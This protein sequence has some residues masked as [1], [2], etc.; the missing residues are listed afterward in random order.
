MT[1]SIL[2]RPYDDCMRCYDP[3]FSLQTRHST[4]N[5]R[6]SEEK[7]EGGRKREKRECLPPLSLLQ[8]KELLYLKPFSIF[9]RSL[10]RSLTVSRTN[11]RSSFPKLGRNLFFVKVQFNFRS[12]FSL[13]LFLMTDD[14]FL[15]RRFCSTMRLLLLVSV[16]ERHSSP[17]YLNWMYP[18]CES[19][20]HSPHTTAKTFFPSK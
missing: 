12:S 5:Q 18:V 6:N 16:L 4:H 13:R 8:I 15:L 3:F 14:D 20:I 9:I 1:Q 7:T 2:Q 17:V 11:L 10:F 19:L